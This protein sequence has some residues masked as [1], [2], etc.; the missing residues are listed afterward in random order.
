MI[1]DSKQFL[2]KTEMQ[3]IKIPKDNSEMNR[4]CRISSPQCGMMYVEQKATDS[5]S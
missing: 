4:R 1:G 5:S 3:F 2:L